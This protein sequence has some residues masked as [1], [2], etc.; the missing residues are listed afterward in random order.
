MEPINDNTGYYEGYFDDGV[1]AG[2]DF[3]L[4]GRDYHP[5]WY[6]FR[7]PIIDCYLTKDHRKQHIT[8]GPKLTDDEIKDIEVKANKRPNNYKK[9]FGV[10]RPSLTIM[11]KLY[12]NAIATEPELPFKDTTLTKNKLCKL[13]NKINRDS[14]QAL[15]K[16]VG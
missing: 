5:E 3:F 1:G 6:I 8:F 13:Y 14:V 10:N 11:K 2:E 7:L 16:M 12:D 9:L 15:I 4:P